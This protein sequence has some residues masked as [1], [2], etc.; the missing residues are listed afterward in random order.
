[1]VRDGATVLEPSLAGCC[2][3]RALDGTTILRLDKPPCGAEIITD[4][5][6][7]AGL[8]TSF[9]DYHPSTYPL[10]QCAAV[11][12]QFALIKVPEQ[13]KEGPNMRWKGLSFQYLASRL[14]CHGISP[15]EAGV[16]SE[17]LD[18][19]LLVL[20]HLPQTEKW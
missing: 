15:R 18:P 16:P 1:M 8:F 9:I 14:T 11:S 2:A 17:I 7:E 5:A 20:P 3:G 10:V 4:I 13:K 6:S 19:F 12:T